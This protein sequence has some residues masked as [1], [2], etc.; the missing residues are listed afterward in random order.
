MRAY[1]VMGHQLVGDLF[2]ERGI[3]AATNIDAISSLCSPFV[4]RSEFRG[5]EAARHATLTSGR[6]LCRLSA[7]HDQIA[8]SGT[9]EATR[10]CRLAR[11]ILRE[12]SR[13][14][15]R[16][17]P[18]SPFHRAVADG[19]SR[20]QACR[21]SHAVTRPRNP[22]VYP[23]HR[24][25]MP[26]EHRRNHCDMVSERERTCA[27]RR[28]ASPTGS[29]RCAAS[30]PL[31]A[32]PRC[33]GGRPVIAADRPES[34]LGRSPRPAL[35][36][37]PIGALPR[38]AGYRDCLSD[39]QPSRVPRRAAGRAADCGGAAA[40]HRRVKPY[41]SPCQSAAAPYLSSIL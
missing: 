32:P 3:E 2:R 41:G 17:A 30:E 13:Q 4:A 28:S 23:P 1:R 40:R 39:L 15:S 26:L 16:L 35:R 20:S 7:N 10:P 34:L 8:N 37:R 19:F 33:L 36:F 27:S 14:R 11:C 31:R 29:R 9:G 12:K 38:Q 25:D 6:M 21:I 24:L 22:T 5:S 18:W